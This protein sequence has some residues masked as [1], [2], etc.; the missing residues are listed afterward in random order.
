M[1]VQI[2]ICD[3]RAEDIVRLS[4]A[5]Y[6]YDPLFEITSFTSGKT[7]VDELKEDSFSAD[8]LFLD[9]YMP[10]M[11]GIKT[12][13]EIRSKKENLKI[14]FLSSSRE[15]Y[16]QAYEVFAYNYLEKPFDQGRLYTVLDR[17]LGEIRKESGYKI[18]IRYKGS[19]HNVDCRDILY[20]ESRDKLLLF[21]FSAGNTL[22]CYGKLETILNE[23]PG[24]FFIRCHQSFLINLLQVTEMKENYMRTGPVMISI[25]RKYCKNVK[26]QYYAYLFSRMEEERL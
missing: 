17:A 16:S 12:A 22:Q 3:D 19:V 20:I 11:D 21:H 15:H 25:S 1:A 18:S 26:E 10:E 14:I 4:R 23:L 2:A 13:Q 9:I 7:L 24:Q 8:I 6:A 5:L